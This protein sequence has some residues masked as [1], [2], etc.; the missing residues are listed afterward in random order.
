MAFK[1]GFGPMQVKSVVIAALMSLL[2]AGTV[3][4][5]P[6]MHL[7]DSQGNLG[8]VDVESGNVNII[9]SMGVTMTDIAFD[10]SG[11]LWGISF[12]GLYSINSSNAS[13][14]YIGNHNIAGGNALVF[15]TDGT[16]YAAGTNTQ[17]LYSVD[18]SNAAATNLG[19]MGFSSGGDLA[20]NSGGFY[21]ASDSAELISIDLNDVSN[22]SSIGGFGVANMYGLATGDDGLLYGVADTTIYGIDLLTGAASNGVSFAAQ[23]MGQA[24]GQSFYTEAGAS[25]VPEPGSLALLGMGILGLVVSRKAKAS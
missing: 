6:I 23:G 18:T 3:S 19:N 24:F 10:T 11:N 2:L 7:H 22:S 20:F 21:M 16:L 25:E 17:N 9:G 8:T 13:A 12:T 4:A 1:K 15:G 14:S 5:G